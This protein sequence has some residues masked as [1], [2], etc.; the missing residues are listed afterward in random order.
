MDVLR[1]GDSIPASI[2]LT[3]ATFQ[4]MGAPMLRLLSTTTALALISTASFA[5]D[6]P[7]PPEPIPAAIV[8]VF[9]WTGF[10]A[11]IGGGGGWIEYDR[12]TTAGFQ[13]SYDADGFFVG[14]QVGYNMQWNWFVGGIEI[15]G[16]WADITGNDGGAGG[17]LDSSEIEWLASGTVHLGIGWDRF[18][19][20]ILGG[21]TG[22]GIEQVNTSGAGWTQD[23]TF[24]GWT[25]GAGVNF[26]LTDHIVIG[27][28]YR[29]TDL[30]DEDFTPTNGILGFNL[31]PENFHQIRGE[32]S[33]KFF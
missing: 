15:D 8:P 31:D 29:Y 30:Q 11:G 27:G 21:I 25:V 13:N 33:W 3:S 1:G 18:N 4:L 16:N 26:A 9:S 12:E 14:G 23:E 6:L 32:I 5:A 20:F 19:P 2:G 7:L 10:Y 24:W 17:T 22:A 28:Q